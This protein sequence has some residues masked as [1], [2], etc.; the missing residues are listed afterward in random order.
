MFAWF[1]LFV[2]LFNLCNELRN[3]DWT[4]KKLGTCEKPWRGYEWAGYA[5]VM[6]HEPIDPVVSMGES[7]TVPAMVAG[8]M[9]LSM[10]E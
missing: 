7:Y 6:G 5:E 8:A 9:F 3:Q 1:C 4:F 2:F 10:D